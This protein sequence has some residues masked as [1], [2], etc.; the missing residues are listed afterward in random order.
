[1]GS[2]TLTSFENVVKTVAIDFEAEIK[3]FLDLS[4]ELKGVQVAIDCP[5]EGLNLGPRSQCGA[6]VSIC[7]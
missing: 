1:M 3:R 7:N 6:V 4:Q 2:V 5:A